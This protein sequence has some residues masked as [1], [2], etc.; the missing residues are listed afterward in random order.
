MYI[1]DV[2]G[3]LLP[4]CSSSNSRKQKIPNQYCLRQTTWPFVCKFLIYESVLIDY[5]LLGKGIK[6]F[7][8]LYD[9]I[10]R[11]D[12]TNQFWGSSSHTYLIR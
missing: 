10:D 4:E 12:D 11:E 7:F 1:I 3:F 2:P 5:S 6:S 8:Q 9:Y